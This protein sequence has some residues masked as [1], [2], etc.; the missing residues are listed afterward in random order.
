MIEILFGIATITAA[1]RIAI[2]IHFERRLRI[3]DYLLLLASG[4]LAASAGFLLYKTSAVV[5]LARTSRDPT[6][7]INEGLSEE[8]LFQQAGAANILNWTFY[9]LSWTSIFLVKSGFLV[10]FKS[11]LQRLPRAY[12]YWKG[13]IVV[14]AVSFVFVIAQ[15]FI[16]CPRLGIAVGQSMTLWCTRVLF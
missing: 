10:L 13:I 9:S 11:L 5:L 12:S 14:T 6:I 3:D 1:G 8:K 7:L 15:P 16:T 2:R 4:F